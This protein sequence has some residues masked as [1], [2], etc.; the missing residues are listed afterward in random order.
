MSKKALT[1]FSGE[2]LTRSGFESREQTGRGKGKTGSHQRNYGHIQN[3]KNRHCHQ[4]NHRLM[5]HQSHDNKQPRR[6]GGKLRTKGEV[7][8]DVMFA[9]FL[10]EIAR[11]SAGKQ[12]HWCALLTTQS[13]PGRWET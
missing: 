8:N 9:E 5:A 7:D 11:F 13:D 4:P 6:K 10:F 1:N 3:W 2:L 12:S